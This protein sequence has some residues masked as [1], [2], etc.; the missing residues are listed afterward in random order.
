MQLTINLPSPHQKQVE[1]IQ[2]TAKR[3]IIRAGRRGGKTVGVSIYAVEKFLSGKRI[4][5]A[6]PT[7]EQVDRFWVS[8]TRALQ[9]PIDAGVFYK[10]ETKHIIE[11]PATEQRIR[12]KTAWNADS[13]RGDYA[14]ILIMDEF[15]L[16]AEDAWNTVG[17]P[18]LADNNGD[19]TFIYTPPSLSS[20]SVSKATDPQNAAKMFKRAVSDTTGRWKAFNFTSYDNPHI[21]KLALDELAQDMTSVAYRMEIMAEDLDEAPGALWK[22]QDI[23]KNRVVKAPE[24]DRVVVGV[25]PSAT[26]GGDEAGIITGGRCGEDY[27]TL[28]DDSIQGSPQEW[29]TAAVTA[30]HKYKAD[31]MVAE[32]NNGGEMVEA[33]IKQ[34]DKTVNVKLVHASRGKATRAEPVAAI[35]EQ[36]RDH[37]VGSFPKLEDEL[38]LWM[39]GDASPNRLDAKVWM[40]TELLSVGRVQVIN[41]PFRD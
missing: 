19:A 33:V 8:V 9:E 12:A 30:Y 13:L 26:S 18:M 31:L 28:S 14:D 5:Y 7:Q 6:A 41:N 38:C 37:H 25:D 4:L 32:K 11:R 15:Q 3:K 24:L 10:N 2:S 27:Y 20:R 35:N 34:V 39:Q 21:S 16:I 17:A 22:R 36:G 40:M 1:F 29:A 23:E